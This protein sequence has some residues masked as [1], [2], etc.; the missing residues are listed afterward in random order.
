MI[1]PLK[2]KFRTRDFTSCFLFRCCPGC[3]LQ[4]PCGWSGRNKTGNEMSQLKSY[5]TSL[6]IKH[7]LYS[8]SEIVDWP[9]CERENGRE[10]ESQSEPKSHHSHDSKHDGND[11]C[12]S[13]CS[14][15]YEVRIRTDEGRGSK[16][17]VNLIKLQIS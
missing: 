10:G 12:F 2:H 1:K 5:F 9:Q 3:L 6:E 7:L 13:C 11:L 14:A 15:I 8:Y 17:E 4:R 16:N